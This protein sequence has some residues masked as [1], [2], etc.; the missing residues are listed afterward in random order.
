MQVDRFAEHMTPNEG[1]FRMLCVKRNINNQSATF[2]SFVP[3]LTTIPG[4]VSA[5]GRYEQARPS[6]TLVQER[7]SH[8]WSV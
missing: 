4:T 3:R 8:G 1:L 5:S 2:E 6:M 7:L